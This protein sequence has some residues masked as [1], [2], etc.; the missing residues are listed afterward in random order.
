MHQI[1]TKSGAAGVLLRH[2]WKQK[3]VKHTKPLGR[4]FHFLN[5]WIK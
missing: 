3:Q 4:D 1:K 2:R 5:G